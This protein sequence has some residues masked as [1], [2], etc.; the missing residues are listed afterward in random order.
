MMKVGGQSGG[1]WTL[2]GIRGTKAR[3]WVLPPTLC[4]GNS[5]ELFGTQFLFVKYE[6]YFRLFEFYASS[7]NL[8]F[9]T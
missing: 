5:W 4:P 8:M 6:I 1:V 2:Y 7:I 9:I 3:H